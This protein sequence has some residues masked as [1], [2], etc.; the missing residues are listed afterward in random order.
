MTQRFSDFYHVHIDLSRHWCPRS[1]PYAG[2]DAL[3][4]YLDD[5]WETQGD[6]D[7]DEHWLGGTRRILVYL[8]VLTKQDQWVTMPVLYNPVLDRLLMQLPVHTVPTDATCA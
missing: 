6:I 1:E 7:Y 8:F 5:G 4:T 3:L 2:V